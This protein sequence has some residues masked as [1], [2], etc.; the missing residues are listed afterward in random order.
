MRFN[1]KYPSQG[2]RYP[3][4]MNEAFGPYAKLSVEPDHKPAI[5]KAFVFILFLAALAVIIS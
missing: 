1:W 3:R 4:T 5:L 2:T